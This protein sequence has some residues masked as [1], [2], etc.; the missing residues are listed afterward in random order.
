LRT[1]YSALHQLNP[2]ST[3]I[4]SLA[5]DGRGI[6]HVLGKSTFIAG[7]L[8]DEE[9]T[10]NYLRKHGRYDEGEIIEILKPSPDRITP[11]CEYCALCAGCSLQHLNHSKQIEFK[12]DVLLNQLLHFGDIQPLEI[13]PPII[14]PIFG[15]RKR[16]RLSVKYVPKKE[17]VLIGFHERNGRFIAEIEQC[18]ILDPRIGEKIFELQHLIAQLS[19]F[20][21]IPQIE[22]AASYKTVGL[23]LRV[24]EQCTPSDVALL[25]NFA[26][27]HNFQI[28]LQT[29]GIDTIKPLDHETQ[30]CP[31][32]S[33]SIPKYDLELV[34]APSDFTQIN[35]AVNLQMIDRAIELLEPDNNDHILD[36]FCGIGNFTLPL[37]KLCKEITGVE[38]APGLV[39]KAQENATRNQIQNATFFTHDLTKEIIQEM[40]TKKKYDKILLDPPRTGAL[41]LC[42]QFGKF[43]PAKIVYVSCN[44]A[45]LARDAKE[46]I[47]HGYQLSKAGIIDMFPHTSHMES[48]ALFERSHHFLPLQNATQT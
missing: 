28:Y 44:P 17:K 32:L 36:L 31:E 33:Y 30:P 19:I 13:L 18:K 37:A 1:K 16:A 11:E 40:W 20:K 6:A 7:A 42:K 48:I 22:I 15:Y 12:T 21:S 29:G 39:K 27:T 3:S 46:I 23:I 2:I 10:F 47:N 35:Q 41:E 25:Q 34:F 5:H 43:R 14:G 4:K 24:L 9:V 26:S 8:P 45:T 38:G